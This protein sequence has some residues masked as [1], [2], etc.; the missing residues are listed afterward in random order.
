MSER[1][2]G[3]LRDDEILDDG[4]Y[5]EPDYSKPL[6]Q[7]QIDNLRARGVEIPERFLAPEERAERPAA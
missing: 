4:Q 2:S 6:P 3:E 1:N 7:W 5:P